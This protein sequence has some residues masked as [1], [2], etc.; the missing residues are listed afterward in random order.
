[1]AGRLRE[2]GPAIGALSAGLMADRYGF[3]AATFASGASSRL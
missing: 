2:L 3:A 1:M